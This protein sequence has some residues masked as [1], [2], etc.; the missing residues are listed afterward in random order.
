MKT[1]WIYAFPLLVLLLLAQNNRIEAGSERYRSFELYGHKYGVFYHPVVDELSVSDFRPHAL[2]N[3][4]ER[5]RQNQLN[6]LGD[7]IRL[8]AAQFQLDELGTLIMVRKMVDAWMPHKGNN[9][10]ILFEYLLL[11]ELGFDVLLTRTG[12]QLNCLGRLDFTPRKF[13]YVS[14]RGQRYVHLDF[15]KAAQGKQH[16]VIPDRQK[17]SAPIRYRKGKIPAFSANEEHR[18]LQMI[19]QGDTL[20]FPVTL[21]Q[22]LIS[23]FY[24]IPLMPLGGQFI[25]NTL[26]P[27]AKQSLY[28]ELRAHLKGKTRSDQLR[29]LLAFV[30]QIVP[31]GSDLDKYGTDYYYFPEQTLV[32]KTADC[33]DKA[34]L[35]ATLS[36]DLL[37][38][39]S[40]GLH[41]KQDQHLALAFELP[42]FFGGQ[43][44]TYK[45]NQYI[46]CEPTSTT[47]V[48]AYSAFDLSRLGGII[49]LL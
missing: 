40:V 5:I 35:L 25:H 39:N 17:G 9:E 11:D 10:K 33:E 47:P 30:Q 13:V 46:P 16:E 45:G 48:L 43:T 6:V 49:D 29:F 36:K 20:I 44:F 3:Q 1:R 21:N 42:G 31:Y 7:H 2:L 19:W 28:P 41:F 24:D 22:S 26:S 32:A 8:S 18:D 15:E 38:I 4:M 37:G 34:F 27:Q 12:K 14:Y 23:Y